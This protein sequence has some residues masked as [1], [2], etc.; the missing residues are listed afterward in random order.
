MSCWVFSCVYYSSE[1][2][3]WSFKIGVLKIFAL[4]TGMHQRW[5][6]FLIKLRT[7]NVFYCDCCKKKL[8]T[9]FLQ[10]T[11]DGC[12]CKM[13]KF[14]LVHFF[15]KIDAIW[16]V[17]TQWKLK[18]TSYRYFQ[19][20]VLINFFIPLKRAEAITWENFVPAKLDPRCKKKDP[21]LPGWNV[22]HVIAR[23]NLW[24]IYNTPKILAKRD[25]ISS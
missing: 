7:F 25:R 4:F 15:L 18:C 12:F 2:K 19:T 13:R 22:L 8:R 23:Y 5:S 24:R 10:N 17:K 20:N 16:V 14:Y 3:S 9:H 1:N 6:L 11:S 21:T